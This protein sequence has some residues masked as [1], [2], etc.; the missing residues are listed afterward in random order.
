MT[1][2]RY[3]HTAT[4]LLDGK[5]LVAGGAPLTRRAEIYDPS[6][7]T[8][9]SA[10]D[11]GTAREQHTATLLPNGEVLIVGGNG[12]SPHLTTAEIFNPA[13]RT[14][15]TTGSLAIGRSGHTATLLTDGRVLIAGGTTQTAQVSAEIYDPTARTFSRVGNMIAAHYRGTATR[16]RDG[17]VLIAG[18]SRRAEIFDPITST[19]SPTGDMVDGRNGEHRAVSLPDG[20]VLVAGG[21]TNEGGAVATAELYD[22]ASGVFSTTGSM[23]EG[24]F[25][26]TAEAL[27][28]GSVLVIAGY[29]S[30]SAPDKTVERY[31]P[32]TG[33]FVHSGF[34]TVPRTRHASVVLRTGE[35][36]VV[37]GQSSSSTAEVA[38][39]P[40]P[41]VDLGPPVVNV[42][43]DRF[44]DA[45]RVAIGS[46]TLSASVASGGFAPVSFKWLSGADFVGAGL[47]LSL[48]RFVGIYTFTLNVTDARGLT[49]SDSLTVTV[50]LPAATAGPQGPEG[51]PGPAGPM[52]PAGPVGP[53]GPP[54]PQG[55]TGP[56]GPGLQPGTEDFLVK[57]QNGGTDVGNSTVYESNSSVGIGTTAPFDTLHVA[58]NNANGAI[59]GYAV[60]NTA[61]SPTAYSGMLFYDHTGAL[62]QFQGFNNSTHEYRINN[63]G[64]VAPDGAFNG[65]INFMIGGT[66]RFFVDSTGNSGIG[67]S[68]PQDR[69]D[70]RGDVRVGSTGTDGCI[71]DF[72]GNPI[73][74]T[75][76]S[77]LRFK[78]DIIP[79]GHVLDQ[80]AVLQPVHYSWRMSEFPHRGF[81]NRRAY[82]LIAQQVEQVLPELVVTGDDGFKA[83]DYSKLPLLTIQAV[84]DLKSENDALK[85]R[86]AELEKFD[87]E[88]LKQ[89]VAELERRLTELLTSA[90]RR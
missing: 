74:G 58:F 28:D 13:T 39:F 30:G 38:A 24:H 36:L 68:T 44:V 66:S 50:Q 10:G 11:L 9:S 7:D 67:T 89:R 90:S 86:L 57:Y 15:A 72:G 48:E 27:P 47:T 32:S 54:G 83:V 41:F 5:V 23:V 45:N 1:I 16:L 77:D 52:G 73:I 55:P 87:P 19:F 82:G 79:F 17:K 42:G 84:K 26:G 71:K 88:A 43:A 80:L 35:V 40:G 29:G 37:G 46:F 59:T 49:T 78:K 64:R 76:A 75:C 4:L 53:A 22:P 33:A 6:T 34:V 18:A 20:R 3:N 62:T 65:S 56:P 63:I 12:G 69:L 25:L 21:T 85:Q 51:P 81:G 31:D 60:Q 61:L 2:P 14:F 70:V 8:F